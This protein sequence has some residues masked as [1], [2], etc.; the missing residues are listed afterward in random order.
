[1][2]ALAEE[3]AEK[4]D[5]A[6]VVETLD[7]RVLARGATKHVSVVS[8]EELARTMLRQAVASGEVSEEEVSKVQV[9]LSARQRERSAAIKHDPGTHMAT[10]DA[11]TLGVFNGTEF[12]DVDVVAQGGKRLETTHAHEQQHEDDGLPSEDL[13]AT[14]AVD[15]GIVEIDDQMQDVTLRDHLEDRATDAEQAAGGEGSPLYL[16]T[17]VKTVKEVTDRGGAAGMDMQSAASA[18][19]ERGD[20]DGYRKALTELAVREAA[21]EDPEALAGLYQEA[22]EQHVDPAV[23]EIIVETRR[24]YA[25]GPQNTS[26][27]DAISQPVIAA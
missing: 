4:Q 21:K 5:A 27:S 10:L 25:E 16:A 11:T 9:A 23:L 15:T 1:M 17:H 7:Q 3:P 13:D 22:V 18:L 26:K 12:I 8:L 24:K 2:F 14:L 19:I 20:V 6:D